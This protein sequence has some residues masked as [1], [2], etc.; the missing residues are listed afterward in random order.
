MQGN[1]VNAQNQMTLKCQGQGQSHQK[2]L[3]SPFEP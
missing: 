2:P 3:K 1:M